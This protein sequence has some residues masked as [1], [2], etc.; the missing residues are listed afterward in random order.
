VKLRDILQI[1]KI[2][3]IQIVGIENCPSAGV[4]SAILEAAFIQQVVDAP[5]Q[6]L[7][8]LIQY[9]GSESLRRFTRSLIEDV[10]FRP[11]LL[12]LSPD[13]LRLWFSTV[14]ACLSKPAGI[15]NFFCKYINVPKLP[16]IDTNRSLL[17]LILGILQSSCS[18]VHCLYNPRGVINQ[19]ELERHRTH[20]NE[21]ILNIRCPKCQ[22]VFAEFEGCFPVT[23]PSC[24]ACFCGWC[25]RWKV[26]QFFLEKYL[27]ILESCV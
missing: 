24:G 7:N 23:R 20:I 4:T 26:L 8:D 10:Q 25:F 16:D 1:T 11:S 19:E 12:Q 27:G 2:T 15:L 6:L 13:V 18:L 14:V 9:I 5:L 22:R 21:Q 3:P 17:N